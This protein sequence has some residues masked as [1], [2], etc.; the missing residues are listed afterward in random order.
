MNEHTPKTD[1]EIIRE[2]AEEEGMTEEEVKEIWEAF[3]QQVEDYKKSKETTVKHSK[4]KRKVKRKMAK[5][6]RKKNR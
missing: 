5:K 4:N 3:Q 2:V 1:D 6:S